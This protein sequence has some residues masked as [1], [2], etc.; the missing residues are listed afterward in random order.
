M[1]TRRAT[2]QRTSE[3]WEA[4]SDC[5]GNAVHGAQQPLRDTRRRIAMKDLNL[6][7]RGGNSWV[8]CGAKLVAS[9]KGLVTSAA[10]GAVPSRWA[11]AAGRAMC[12]L[13]L[14][15]VGVDVGLGL[16]WRS[17]EGMGCPACQEH[18]L[19]RPDMGFLP[20]GICW[21][22]CPNY[23]PRS[24]AGHARQGLRGSLF[25]HLCLGMHAAP[26]LLCACQDAASYLQ[27]AASFPLDQS[28]P[29]NEVKLVNLLACVPCRCYAMQ[30]AH[31]DQILLPAHKLGCCL[32]S[33]RRLEL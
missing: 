13:P 26:T 33:A 12:R 30:G 19:S 6:G 11:V 27:L 18:L 5:C 9:Q 2:C 25:C 32:L 10:L 31:S 17:R 24:I 14:K 4:G 8:C 29:T 7:S 20:T 23:N 1:R 15:L 3:C 21:T 22:L 28:S 16:P